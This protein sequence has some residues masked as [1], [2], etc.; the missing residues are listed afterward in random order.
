MFRYWAWGENITK[1][2]ELDGQ[3]ALNLTFV[4]L[5]L[6]LFYFSVQKSFVY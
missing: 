3:V 4:L 5:E 6:I 2:E 1:A